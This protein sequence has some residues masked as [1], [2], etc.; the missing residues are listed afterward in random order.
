ML[1]TQTWGDLTHDQRVAKL[2][3]YAKLLID[4]A[5]FCENCMKDTYG[6]FEDL[7][8]TGTVTEDK[9]ELGLLVA[10]ARQAA[11]RI[12][13]CLEADAEYNAC[14]G[15]RGLQAIPDS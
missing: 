1:L 5:K 13:T 2:K 10:K 3:E 7:G 9:K 8:V 14:S 6:R 4:A 12:L 15:G 11:S